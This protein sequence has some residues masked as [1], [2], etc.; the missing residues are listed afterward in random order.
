MYFDYLG[1]FEN[2]NFH[3]NMSLVTFWATL[4]DFGQF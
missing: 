1:G 3:V 4:E 2:I